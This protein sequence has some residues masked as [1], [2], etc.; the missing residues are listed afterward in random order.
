MNES[1]ILTNNDQVLFDSSKGVFTINSDNELSTNNL[2][3]ENFYNLLV[4]LQQ[5][6]KL[7]LNQESC[8]TS[9][10]YLSP[11]ELNLLIDTPNQAVSEANY[12]NEQYEYTQMNDVSQSQM[13]NLNQFDKSL[14]DFN[15]QVNQSKSTNTRTGC[16]ELCCLL[17]FNVSDDYGNIL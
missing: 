17:K 11:E 16:Q 6:N 7:E 15:D 9:Q 14:L 1:Q 5:N 13:N 3:Q 10:F 8:L 2:N 12:S 4:K